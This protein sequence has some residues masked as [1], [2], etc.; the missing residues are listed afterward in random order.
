L[1]SSWLWKYYG[2]PIFSM[3]WI[4]PAIGATGLVLM[5]GMLTVWRMIRER[6]TRVEEDHE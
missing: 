2:L 4:V 5:G 3:G 1:K 6:F